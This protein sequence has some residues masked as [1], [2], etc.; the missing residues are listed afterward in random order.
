M[1]GAGSWEFV[2]LEICWGWCGVLCGLQG[3]CLGGS[4]HER[5]VL[6]WIGAG[7]SGVSVVL[8]CICG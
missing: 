6:S 8:W 5:A 2:A 4:G 1:A 3:T 7:L